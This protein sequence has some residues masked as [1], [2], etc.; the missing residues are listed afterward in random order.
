MK[1]SFRSGI[2]I[3]DNLLLYLYTYFGYG[4][5]YGLGR[6]ILR[7][8]IQYHSRGWGIFG[9]EGYINAM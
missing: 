8:D 7:L 5:D 6:A 3:I 1:S 9:M 4:V 2:L